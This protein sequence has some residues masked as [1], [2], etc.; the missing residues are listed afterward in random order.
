MNDLRLYAI[1]LRLAA[2]RPGAIPADHGDQARAALLN[3]IRRGDLSLAQTLHD[4]N[5]RKPYTISLL[6]GGKRGG[7]SALHFGVGDRA[8]W[9]FTLLCEP[10]FEAL[11]RRYILSRDLPH[12]RIGAVEF[13]IV[14]AFASG[15]HPDSG[16]VTLPALHDRWSQ[17]PQSLPH[18][19]MLDFL[20]PT[21]FNLGQDR[22]SGRYRIRST[23]DA[24]TLFSTLRKRWIKLGGA[25]PGDEFDV[26]VGEQ[27]ETLPFDLHPKTVY[28]ER[29]PVDGFIGR[30]GFTLHG[31]ELRWLPLLHLL[32]DL[33]FWTGA[34]YQ[35]S[36]GMGQVRRVD[37]SDP[38]G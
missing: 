26:W 38:H 19:I 31:N 24:R 30:V 22:V 10:A 2:L 36:R 28:V 18:E 14:D 21:A 6:S 23:P 15:S 3:L 11:L 35:T 25:A 33:T 13:Q 32:S 9:R 1:V 12:M 27:I 20:S 37:A 34:G 17:E 8:D 29:R 4:E 7:D 16:S 5:T